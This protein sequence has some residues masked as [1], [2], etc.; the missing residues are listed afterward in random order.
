MRSIAIVI[1]FMLLW[2]TCG[3]T[4]DSP[5]D[6]NRIGIGDEVIY[7]SGRGTIVG[8]QGYFSPALSP[9]DYP[10][11]LPSG[12]AMSSFTWE[13]GAPSDSSYMMVYLHGRESDLAKARRVRATG[14]WD[15]I[16]RTFSMGVS[17]YINLSI[18][19]LE[20]LE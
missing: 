13:Q 11:P 7:A 5:T 3:C 18:D 16:E 10:P 9:F 2:L 14:T 17:H 6:Q 19:S 1:S 4:K 12:Y 20:I 15:A 8:W